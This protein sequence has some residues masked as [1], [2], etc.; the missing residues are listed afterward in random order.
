MLTLIFNNEDASKIVSLINMN[1]K[2]E[3]KEH[4]KIAKII[5]F[6]DI[7]VEK[8]SFWRQCGFRMAE[9]RS[10]ANEVCRMI[11]HKVKKIEVEVDKIKEEAFVTIEY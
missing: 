1:F 6:Q 8:E 11:N 5:K 10:L 2:N 7:Q 9:H 4:G 3:P